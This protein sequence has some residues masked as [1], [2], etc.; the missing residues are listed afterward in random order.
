MIPGRGRPPGGGNGNPLQ[1]SCLENLQTEGPGGQQSTGS[2]RGSVWWR[3]VNSL[4]EIPECSPFMCQQCPE[5]LPA[6]SSRCLPCRG[7]VLPSGGRYTFAPQLCPALGEGIEPASR[8]ARPSHGARG[9]SYHSCPRSSV[10]TQV[11]ISL[12]LSLMS[13]LASLLTASR[14]IHVKVVLMPIFTEHDCIW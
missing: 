10:M 5:F 8:W 1:C 2:Q 14:K 9:S 3:R 13:C 12:H 11:C 7:P 6:V 4:P